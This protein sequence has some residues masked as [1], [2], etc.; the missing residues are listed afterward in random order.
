MIQIVINTLGRGGAERSAL[1]LAEGLLARGEAVSI[2]CLF[3]EPEEYEPAPA[4]SARVV[5]L[6]A[7]SLPSAAW[8]LWAHLRRTRPA[9]MY[10][11]LPQ[12]NF[13]SVIGGFLTG[14][15]IVTSERVTPAA[16]YRRSWKLW[17]VLLIHL[18]ARRAVF[19]SRHAMEQGVPEGRLGRS[20][21]RKACVL[22]NPVEVDI[23]VAA[24]A[25]ARRGRQ[26]RLDRFVRSGRG[27]PLCLL[28]LGRL[29]E[30]KGHIDFLRQAAAFVRRSNVEIVL[31]GKG[32]EEPA[33]LACARELG[34]GGKIHSRGFV[35]DP[36]KEYEACDAVVLTS[37]S[38]GFGRVGFEAYLA[39]C[40][41]IGTPANSFPGEVTDETPGWVITDDFA[42]LDRCL[43]I[44]AARDLPPEG[45]DI[46][47][48]KAALAASTHAGRF[49]EILGDA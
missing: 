26:D 32:A 47:A 19:I 31:A 34:I 25:R 18:C 4:L 16:F 28:L 41:V 10:S 1:T 42:D 39:G 22:H 20:V 40:F 21:R 46:A 12:A 9:V 44:A 48:M 30:G 33:I 43:A 35:H 24:A 11:L 3:P 27:D 36:L 8:R 29:A 15:P 37:E 23:G 13:V 6:Q 2:V 45:S 7:R 17:M 49:L 5:R 14:I 38:E